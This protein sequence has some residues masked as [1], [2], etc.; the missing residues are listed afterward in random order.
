MRFILKS[1]FL[2]LF[3]SYS[4]FAQIE[5]PQDLRVFFQNIEQKLEEKTIKPTDFKELRETLHEIEKNANARINLLN[6]DLSR[7][8]ELL[9]TL[10]EAPEKDSG[11]T[12]ATEIT[13]QR[14][15]LE[16]NIRDID[17]DIK[18]AQLTIVRSEELYNRISDYEEIL[19]RKELLTQTPKL[20]YPDGLWQAWQQT[21]QYFNTINHWGYWLAFSI[22]LLV[23][24]I[25]CVSIHTIMVY[26]RN[27]FEHIK[28]KNVSERLLIQL[29]ISSYFICLSRFHVIEFGELTYFR[30][31]LQLIS[32]TILSIS[33]FELL[34]KVIICFQSKVDNI[35]EVKGKEDY[36]KNQRLRKYTRYAD[37][38]LY[39]LRYVILISPF[40]ALL[41]YT[42]IVAYINLN[43]FSVVGSVGLFYILRTFLISMTHY[44]SRH[45]GKTDISPAFIMVFEPILL[46]ISFMVILFFWGTSFDEMGQWFDKY[47]T[48]IKIG[49]LTLNFNDMGAAI[50]SFFA[51][52][53]LTKIVKWFLDYR[54]FKPIELNAGMKNAILTSLGYAG[55]VFALISASGALGLDMSN[56]AIVAGALSVGIGFGMQAIFNNFVSGLILLFERPFKVGDWVSVGEYQGII[57]RI[58]VRSTELETFANLSII[59][60]NSQMISD[61]VTNWTLYDL[62][63]RVDIAV[64]VAY[65]S[66]IDLVQ[67]ILLECALAHE[68]VCKDPEATVFFIN[69]G[70]SSL[71]FELKC[72]IFDISS[73]L[74][75]TSDL[76]SMIYKKFEESNIEIPFP[77]RVLTIK[78]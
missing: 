21:G 44:S 78:S 12:E 73:K 64:G 35:E 8:K 31:L 65:G 34:G 56:F 24:I 72:F 22:S 36:L 33:L 20:Y 53:L 51:V 67:K 46:L 50:I 6:K 40:I 32:G 37:L 29:F 3:F 57:K 49:Q 62:V 26:Y 58:R 11:K 14:E 61:V 15:Q 54:I 69:F 38:F 19:V 66:D 5:T 25:A 74:R 7:Q 68:G 55:I 42:E 71:D 70:E 27:H 2:L 23:I 48:G 1:F 17:G 16:K 13:L 9:K 60:P 39:I 76:R 75:V 18:G 30:A 52:I 59:V 41:G 4:I 47:S 63:G 28:T 77:Q 45:L 43:I 10:G